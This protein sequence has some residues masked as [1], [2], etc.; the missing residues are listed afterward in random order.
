MNRKEVIE[1]RINAFPQTCR[2]AGLKV[3]PQRMAI[4]AMLA[5]TESHPSPEEVYYSIQEQTPSISLATVYKILDLFMMQGFIR[6]ISTRDQVTRYDANVNPHHHIICDQCGTIEDVMPDEMALENV[7]L[8]NNRGFEISS[9]ELQI[10][11]I[12]STCRN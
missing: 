12:C 6:K 10:H 8:P 9:V 11:G 4:F 5:S 3:T 1:S 2:N 7:N